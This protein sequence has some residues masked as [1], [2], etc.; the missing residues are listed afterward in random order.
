MKTEQTIEF[1]HGGGLHGLWG[2]GVM[3]IFSGVAVGAGFP[4]FAGRL[5]T[6]PVAVVIGFVAGKAMGGFI[7]RTSGAAAAQVYAPT[8]AGFYTQTFSQIDT[9]E[10]R[11]DC[12]GAVAAWE[13]VAVSQP[14]NPWPLIRAGELYFRTLHDPEMAL[15][16]FRHARDVVGIAPEHHR[17]ASQKIIDLLLG[18][19]RDDGRALVELRRL[20]D[21]HPGTREAEGAREALAKLKAGM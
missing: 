3:L 21:Q 5:W 6:I 9:L 18:P 11:G 12:R 20:I 10:A 16:R 2:A 4:G 7:L 8:R 19:L 15:E 13:A 17:Y 1:T 14:Q